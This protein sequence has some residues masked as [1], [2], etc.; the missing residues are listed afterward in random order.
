MGVKK[1]KSTS[2]KKVSPQRTHSSTRK[3]THK[4]KSTG[5]GK[6]KEVGKGKGKHQQR[7]GAKNPI[8]ENFVLP[9]RTVSDSLKPTNITTTKD[10]RSTSIDSILFPREKK[11]KIK[12]SAEAQ[13]RT[14]SSS[15]TKK[16][17]KKSGKNCSCRRQ[18]RPS[19]AP[20][21]K[22]GG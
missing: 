6:K 13:K 5:K 8:A 22:S 15:Q 12:K 21:K 9:R 2:L 20:R 17:T 11:K 19:L 1:D 18:R 4:K 16:K 3:H 14:H 7:V 10:H